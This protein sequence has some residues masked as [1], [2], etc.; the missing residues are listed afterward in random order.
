MEKHI[1]EALKKAGLDRSKED[2]EK[3]KKS[4]ERQLKQKD[5]CQSSREA[6]QGKLEK[7]KA[8]LKRTNERITK[9]REFVL[10]TFV[11]YCK[12]YLRDKWDA[13]VARLWKQF[14]LAQ[15]KALSVIGSRQQGY[16]TQS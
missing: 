15:Q 10:W 13:M 11:K 6:L 2:L 9:K 12:Q 16:I 14:F 8:E 4:F 3:Q 5:L 1:K 7:V